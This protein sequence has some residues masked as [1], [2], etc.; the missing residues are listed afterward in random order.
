MYEQVDGNEVGTW[1]G[2]ITI[3]GGTGENTRIIRFIHTANGDDN[4]KFITLEDCR[5]MFEQKYGGET[6]CL[7]IYV[8]FDDWVH[9]EIYHY[10]NYGNNE[11]WQVGQTIGFA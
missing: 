5:K 1:D 3:F 6:D 11:W 2:F 8:W 4:D 7:S 10:N 9:G